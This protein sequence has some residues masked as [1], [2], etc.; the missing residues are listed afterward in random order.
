MTPMPV[1]EA[2]DEALRNA[3]DAERATHEKAYLKSDLEHYGVAV[4]RI[5][6]IAKDLTAT[7]PPTHDGLVVLA[8]QLWASPMYEHRA[9]AVELLVANRPLLGRDDI[10]LIERL[11]RESHTW[12]LVDNLA[13]KVAGALVASDADLGT[14]LDRWAGDPDFW[15]RRSAL[16]ALLGPL[17]AGGGDFDRFGRYADDLLADT[18]FFVRKAIG[19]VLRDTSKK[20][21]QLVFDWLLPRAARASGVTIRE[22]V[23][24]L[25]DE[26]RDAVL[27]AR[28]GDAAPG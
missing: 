24:R 26:Q 13:E 5:R 4:P 3:G 1:P 12:A 15:L 19:W 16:L 2:I 22:A 11:L 20:R 17:R 18:E 28:G 27:T 25:S 8:D 21:P 9:L 10:A 6:E 23:K 7:E 14:V